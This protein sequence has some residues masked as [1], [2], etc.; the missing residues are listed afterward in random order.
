M[1]RVGEDGDQNN[2][3]YIA[4]G[5]LAW[6]NFF[7]KQFGIVYK[8]QNLY[9]P[10]LSRSTQSLTLGENTCTRIL[11]AVLSATRK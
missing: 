1:L 6:N 5:S 2:L 8:V 7:E 3:F 10:W 9:T 4:G 11:I